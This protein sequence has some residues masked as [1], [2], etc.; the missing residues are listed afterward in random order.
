MKESSALCDFLTGNNL[1]SIGGIGFCYVTVG[2]FILT[3]FGY[4]VVVVNLSFCK[5]G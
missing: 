1:G 5:Y 4:N 3:I 2:Y